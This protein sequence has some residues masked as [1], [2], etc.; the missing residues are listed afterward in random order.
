M[1]LWRVYTKT[2]GD[3]S[4][5]ERLVS[6]KDKKEAREKA[7]ENVKAQNLGKGENS[8]AASQ[9]NTTVLAVKKAGKNGVLCTSR[10]PLSVL[11]SLR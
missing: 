9:A 2:E 7:L 11:D 4:M 5:T 8:Q 3:E 6:A 10:I 1:E